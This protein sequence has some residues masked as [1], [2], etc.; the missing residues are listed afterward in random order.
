M[1][2]TYRV[3]VGLLA[4]TG[5]RIGEAIGLDRDDL[6]MGGGIVTIRNGKFGKAR[7]L[8]LH[9]TTVA[10]LQNYLLRADRPGPSGAP[11]LSE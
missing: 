5:M 6:D 11:V 1:Q 7:A 4:V 2:A 9:P 8:P 3:L 10:V